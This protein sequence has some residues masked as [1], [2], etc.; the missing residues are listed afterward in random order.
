M[1]LVDD[2]GISWDF[3]KGGSQWKSIHV[4]LLVVFLVVTDGCFHHSYI[5]ERFFR[6][7]A[8]ESLCGSGDSFHVSGGSF[9]RFL[10]KSAVLPWKPRSSLWRLLPCKLQSA[11]I[12][13]S[14]IF[15]EV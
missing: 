2:S 4:Q 12:V 5:I 8:G 10:R 6:E 3:G 9:H 14:G 11:S 7:K 13:T 15:T 1:K